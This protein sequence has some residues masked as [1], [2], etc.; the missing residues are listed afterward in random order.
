MDLN[1]LKALEGSWQGTNRLWLDPTQEPDVSQTEM[2]ITP[3]LHDTFVK[4]EYTW[5]FQGQPHEGLL[6]IGFKEKGGFF[7]AWTDTFHVA[8]DLM[9]FEGK[10]GAEGVVLGGTYKVDDSPEWGWDIEI[11]LQGGAFSFLMFNI[12]PDGLRMPAVEAI[13]TRK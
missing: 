13:Y 4:L 10:P 5:S 1:G 11:Q 9:R 6:L 7:A 12:M 3:V 8:N 2:R